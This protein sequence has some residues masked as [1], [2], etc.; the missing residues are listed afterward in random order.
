MD[1][2][3]SEVNISISEKNTI[4]KFEDN[5]TPVTNDKLPDSEE[6]LAI[7]EE[8]L[9]KLKNDPNIL[10]QLKAKRESCM[11]QFMSN[12]N[13]IDLELLDLQEP[14]PNNPLLRTVAPQRQALE[15]SEIVELVKYDQLKNEEADLHVNKDC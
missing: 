3:L 8:K 9:K 13:Q 5:F 12:S 11:E 7:L 2:W 14:L 6:Y 1:P 4:S 10:A 15:Q